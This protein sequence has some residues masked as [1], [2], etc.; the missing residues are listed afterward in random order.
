MGIKKLTDE[1]MGLRVS[2]FQFLI[3]IDKINKKKERGK[4]KD[5]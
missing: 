1:E 5:K 4:K 3:K 2:L